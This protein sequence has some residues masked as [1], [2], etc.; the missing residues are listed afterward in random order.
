MIGQHNEIDLDCN[1]SVTI[2]CKLQIRIQ[3]CWNRRKTKILHNFTHTNI[4]HIHIYIRPATVHNIHGCSHSW[5]SALMHSV[6]FFTLASITI[7]SF[8]VFI[9][10][11]VL[12]LPFKYWNVWIIFEYNQINLFNPW[13]QTIRKKELRTDLAL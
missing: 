5:G 10:T 4:G 11:A 13:F 7:F 12:P 3:F 6:I 2:T 9:L 8:Y 1:C